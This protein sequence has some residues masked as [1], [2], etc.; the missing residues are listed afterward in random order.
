MCCVTNSFEVIR[1]DI[2]PGFN[3][4]GG[5]DLSDVLFGILL[6]RE[7]LLSTGSYCKEYEEISENK[8]RI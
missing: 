6:E 8:T 7:V 3:V 5:I 2:D 1:L 4:Q